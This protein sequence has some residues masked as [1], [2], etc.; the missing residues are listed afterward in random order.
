MLS[1]EE[2]ELL[3]RVGPGTPMGR[4]MRRFWLPVCT[5]EQVA[6]PDSAPL[7]TWMLCENYVVFRDTEGR[8]GVLEEYC[9][10]SPRASQVRARGRPG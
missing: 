9:A 5:S 3:T 4:M 2:N 6:L 1:R 7:R 8:V 10:T